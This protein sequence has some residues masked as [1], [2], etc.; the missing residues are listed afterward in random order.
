M[1]NVSVTNHQQYAVMNSTLL[2][3]QKDPTSAPRDRKT[4][5][6][7][8]SSIPEAATLES[9]RRWLQGEKTLSKLNDAPLDILQLSLARRGKS[10]L[11]A[12]V[13][14]KDLPSHIPNS[15]GELE[16]P[17]HSPINVDDHFL[18]LTVLYEGIAPI[19]VK[20]E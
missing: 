11:Q 14:I 12:T 10:T 16:G 3:D 8:V 1:L 13:T 4:K 19:K 9:V 20:A 7:R 5:T 6:L 15:L 18:G 2:N 17:D